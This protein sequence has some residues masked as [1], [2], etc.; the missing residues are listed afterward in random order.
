MDS[1]TTKKWAQ[2]LIE[3][4]ILRRL[5]SL[6][7]QKISE[8]MVRKTW[9]QGQQI[10][11]QGEVGTEFFIILEGSVDVLVY[12]QTSQKDGKVASLSTGDYFGDTALLSDK[13]RN[14]SIICDTDV[15]TLSLEKKHFLELFGEKGFHV[16]FGRRKAKLVN[17]D[18]GVEKDQK[19]VKIIKEAVNNNPLFAGPFEEKQLNDL[20]LAMRPRQY[21]AKNPI[22]K[23]GDVAENFYVIESGIVEMREN[24]KFVNTRKSGE[25][26]GEFALLYN[27]RRSVSAI[28]KTDCKL[29]YVDRFKFKKI[30]IKL[31]DKKIEEYCDFLKKVASLD[32]LNNDERKRIAAVLDEVQFK[33]NEVISHED[34]KNSFFM[35]R[36]GCASVY[37][38]AIHEDGSI[39]DLEP[40]TRVGP[41]EVFGI[42]TFCEKR[43][44]QIVVQVVGTELTCLC[45]DSLSYH[46]LLSAIHDI[47]KHAQDGVL[48]KQRTGFSESLTTSMFR[49]KRKLGAGQYGLVEVVELKDKYKDIFSDKKK[50]MGQGL[51]HLQT[52]VKIR[53]WCLL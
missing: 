27:C 31:P 12:D 8:K 29:W 38:S 42:E 17:S 15:V 51:H 19:T 50:I 13:K 22:I 21:A 5:S 53:V 33:S 44:Q 43:E 23:Q 49:R 10:I 52:P 45:L 2:I 34:C 9:A 35:V 25:S 41:G 48:S 26:F 36:S 47:I 4:P 40:C 20:V 39:G 14:A 32:S 16:R 3:V 28:A 1:E 7:R 37:R 24:N 11:K 6:E 46:T 30:L 18:R